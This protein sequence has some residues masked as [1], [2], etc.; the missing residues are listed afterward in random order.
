MNYVFAIL[1]LCKQCSKQCQLK[2]VLPRKGG[3]FILWVF[4][5]QRH[6]L[7]YSLVTLCLTI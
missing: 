5:S 7:Y 6:G 3:I 4:I 2:L 1:Y